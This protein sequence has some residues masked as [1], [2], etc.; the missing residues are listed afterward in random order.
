MKTIWKYPV[1]PA[2]T[3]QLPRHAEVLTVQLQ[4]G[5]PVMWVLLDPAAPRIERH[6][7]SCVTGGTIADSYEKREYIGTFQVEG[8]DFHLF[9]V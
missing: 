2:M 3:V 6:F 1:T 9:E 4:Q 8:F 7:E 5:I